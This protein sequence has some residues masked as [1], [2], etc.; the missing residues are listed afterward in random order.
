MVTVRFACGHQQEEDTIAA[1][2]CKVCGETRVQMVKAPQPRFRGACR[3]P[4]VET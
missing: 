4:C 2:Q 1:P 3:G